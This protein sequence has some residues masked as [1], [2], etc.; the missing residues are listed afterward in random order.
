MLSL[1][2]KPLF[3]KHTDNNNNNYKAILAFMWFFNGLR[4]V[5]S[6]NVRS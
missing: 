6:A 1:L 2:T 4:I 5:K 3:Q